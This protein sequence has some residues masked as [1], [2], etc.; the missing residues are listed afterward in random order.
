M[1]LT[2]TYSIE[3]C[4]WCN[5]LT[6]NHNG[7]TLP[8]TYTISYSDNG[9]NLK[10]TN[11][12]SGFIDSSITSPTSIE[13]EITSASTST[14]YNGLWTVKNTDN[15][16]N[17]VLDSKILNGK[18]RIGTTDLLNN[19]IGVYLLKVYSD[20]IEVY[21]DDSLVYTVNHALNELYFSLAS[22][23]GTS[24]TFTIKGLKF[25]PL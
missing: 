19:P 6:A 20:K 17:R 5:T 25:K 2:K 15:D 1:F 9:M 14:A 24:N 4:R 12:N 13:Y 21:K 10:N 22:G 18:Y 16:N 8:N 23:S 3:D 7:I 11:W